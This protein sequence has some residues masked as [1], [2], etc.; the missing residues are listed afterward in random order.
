MNSMKALITK[1]ATNTA[2]FLKSNILGIF[3][4]GISCSVIASFI[5]SWIQSPQ[6]SDTK[7]ISEIQSVQSTK[8][9]PKPMTKPLPQ[10][11]V[12][13]ILKLPPLQQEDAGSHYVGQRFK[14][15][16]AMYGGYK[17]FDGKSNTI[18]FRSKSAERFSVSVFC[19]IPKGEY[20]FLQTA[21]E[22]A[23]FYV[24][25]TV[26]RVRSEIIYLTD[27]TIE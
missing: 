17:S 23:T 20:P 3:I 9:L 1:T 11:I 14:W 18:H 12:A 24:T 4:V 8:K 7:K 6:T 2:S 10:E 19:D 22:G 13:E 5:F 15:H 25:G 26:S 16:V 21:K 27:T